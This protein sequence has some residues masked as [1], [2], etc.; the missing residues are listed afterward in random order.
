MAI[1]TRINQSVRWLK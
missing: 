1:G